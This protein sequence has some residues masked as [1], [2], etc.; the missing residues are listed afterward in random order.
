MQLVI[1][2]AFLKRIWRRAG[3]GRPPAVWERRAY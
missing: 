3:M 2:Q 1:K